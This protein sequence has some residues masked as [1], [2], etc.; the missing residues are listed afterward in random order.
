MTR[1]DARHSNEIKNDW[2]APSGDSKASQTSKP[3]PRELRS[4]AQK[5]L[6]DSALAKQQKPTTYESVQ[7]T[8]A[9]DPGQADRLIAERLRGHST[10]DREIVK[11]AVAQRG[12]T[13]L[14]KYADAENALRTLHPFGREER[15]D[16]LGIMKSGARFEAAVKDERKELVA[17]VQFESKAARTN[18]T[19]ELKSRSLSNVRSQA[20]KVSELGVKVTHLVHEIGKLD[21][22]AEFAAGLGSA[23]GLVGST[24]MGP[25]EM[26]AK[27]N[28]EPLHGLAERAEVAGGL[29]LGHLTDQI[30]AA[31]RTAG[32]FFQASG[33]YT[34]ARNRYE[35]AARNGD[36]EGMAKHSKE[37]SACVKE[38]KAQAQSLAS[39]ARVIAKGN[40]QFEHAAVEM[41]IEAVTISLSAGLELSHLGKPVHDVIQPIV[42][43][44]MIEKGLSIA[45]DVVR[46][47]D[48]SD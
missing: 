21:R 39:Q 44:G 1:V 40:H 9:R 14:R 12:N 20:K 28:T 10:T 22:K 7:S 42:M 4:P 24:T 46:K 13:G 37:M 48:T 8:L 34:D 43:D 26:F 11:L 29:M 16:I 45:S 47:P 3:K 2:D 23:A 25:I 27:G 30:A 17:P 32:R 33:A 15:G 5:S 6:V 36:Y 41:A 19:A 38:M 31:D 18:L 35:S